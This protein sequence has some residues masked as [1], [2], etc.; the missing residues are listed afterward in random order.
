MEIVL[1]YIYI[2]Y[3]YIETEEDVRK[4]QTRSTRSS[5]DLMIIGDLVCLS[6]NRLL[7]E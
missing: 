7:Y 1:N 3:F 5:L 2:L 4:L 6:A